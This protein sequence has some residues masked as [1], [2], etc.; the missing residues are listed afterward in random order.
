M[1][2]DSNFVRE[3]SKSCSDKVSINDALWEY[4]ANTKLEL[5]LTKDSIYVANT[6][7]VCVAE[8]YTNLFG[9]S[10]SS[11]EINKN[12]LNCREITFENLRKEKATMKFT[13]SQDSFDYSVI[14][15]TK[16]KTCIHQNVITES[17]LNPEGKQAEE[18]GR[19]ILSSGFST[20]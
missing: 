5:K 9:D 20:K 11:P 3:I 10:T 7:D 4:R 12:I 2:D 1:K 6:A 17:R 18:F 15:Q 19:C 13:Q 16:D 8:I 14:F